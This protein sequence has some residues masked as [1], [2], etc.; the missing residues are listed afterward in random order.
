MKSGHCWVGDTLCNN[1]RC[2][3]V[4]WSD[5]LEGELPLKSTVQLN[6]HLVNTH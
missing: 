5:W 1:E 2:S 4:E 3:K 6:Q